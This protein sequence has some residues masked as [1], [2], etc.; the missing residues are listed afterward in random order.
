MKTGVYLIVNRRSGTTYVGSAARSLAYRWNRH[1]EGLNRGEHPN[2]HL[3]A[4]WNKYG[5]KSF[6]FVIAER[7]H[8]DL[9]ITKE[10]E[11]MDAVRNSGVELYNKCP[12]AGST[13]G[14]KYTEEQRAAVTVRLL[15]GKH[16][17][18]TKRKMS[19]SRLAHFRSP[20][21]KANREAISKAQRGRIVSEEAKRKQAATKKAMYADPSVGPRLRE[22]VSKTWKGKKLSKSHR[23]AVAK[24]LRKLYDGPEGDA[25]RF[26]MRIAQTGRKHSEETKRRI[27]E[28]NTGKSLSEETKS[29][30]S[31]AQSAYQQSLT[32]EE[33]KRRAAVIALANTGQKRS[34][35]S[36]KRI[37]DALKGHQLSEETRRRISETRKARFAAGAYR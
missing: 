12:V 13:L 32:E 24:G 33:R 10:Q 8:P 25:A 1:R 16:S 20:L 27:S 36:R 7:C 15:G 30:I 26:K 3:Q 21:G 11:W 14:Y 37:S 35:E 18:E 34:A 4:A 5:R 29:K 6:V 19:E 22:A 31:A 17:E 9:C 28:G 23:L 2:K